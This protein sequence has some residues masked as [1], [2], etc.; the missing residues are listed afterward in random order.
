METLA[1]PHAQ[2]DPAWREELSQPSFC[3]LT[4]KVRPS[5]CWGMIDRN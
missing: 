2:Y 5:G 1:I 4:N 3:A